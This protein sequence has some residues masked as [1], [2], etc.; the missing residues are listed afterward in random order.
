[1]LTRTA[2][3]GILLSDGRAVGVKTADGREYRARAVVANANAPEL[4]ADLLPAGSLPQKQQARLASF[5]PS[6]GSC[7]VWL[8]LDRDITRQFA[9]PEVSYYPGLDF[10][11]NYAASMAGDF[12]KC[13]FSL[14]AY[15]NLVPGFSPPGCSTVSLVCLSGYEPWRRFEADYRAGRKEDYEREKRRVADLLIAR[16]EA[17]ALPGLSRMIVM[18]EASTPLTNVRFTRNAFGSIYGYAPSVDNA[19]LSRFP[20]TTAIPGL[21][22]ASAWGSPGGGYTGALLGGKQTFKDVATAL[23]GPGGA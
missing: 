13:S 3:T 2:V 18:R 23:A 10:E 16:A 5:T 9:D 14:M 15:D 22:L 6:P 4:F 12:E 17:L 1:M 8:G 20:N 21:Y 11:A 7:I 19:F